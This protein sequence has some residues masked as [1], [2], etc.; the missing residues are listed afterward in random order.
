V[1]ARIHTDLGDL[2]AATADLDAAANPDDPEVV[3]SRAYLA[4]ARGLPGPDVS[5][6]LPWSP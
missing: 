4:H 5:R 6:L 1:L 3:A 2:E